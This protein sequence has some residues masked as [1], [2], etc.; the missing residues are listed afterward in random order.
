MR[1][2]RFVRTTGAT[3]T[4]LAEVAR[5]EKP[6]VVEAAITVNP[7]LLLQSSTEADAHTPT[8][9]QHAGTCG[10]VRSIPATINL[11]NVGEAV[12]NDT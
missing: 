4:S 1:R 7:R 5:S 2:G 11:A 9:R 6:E 12:I 8:P 10:S 3:A